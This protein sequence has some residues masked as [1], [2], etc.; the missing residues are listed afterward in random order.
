MTRRRRVAVDLLFVTG[1]R[2]G[3]ETYAREL[4]PRLAALLEGV[5]LVAVT[6]APGADLVRGWFPGLVVQLDLNTGRRAAWAAAE[7]LAAG[8][9]AARA[10][11]DLLWCP[12]NY[13]PAGGSVPR[14]VT[15]HD[16]IPFEHV[17]PGLGRAGQRVTTGLLR[18]AAR[19]ATRLLAVSE[20][21]ADRSARVLGLPRDRFCVVP[22]GAS[23]LPIP[24]APRVAL[25]ALGVPFDR[26]LV[27]STGNRMPHKNFPL[28][29]RALAAIP[30]GRRPRLV[31]PGGGADD[32]LPAMVGSL[33]L[34][35]DVLL[36]GWL[37]AE[38]LGAL[39]A[40]AA[41]Y[42]CPSLDEGFGLPVVDAMRAGCPVLAS[43]I[44]VLHEVGEDAVAYVDARDAGALAAA[45]E[46]LLGDPERRATLVRR[47]RT[48][49]RL[50]TWDRSAEL[51]AQVVERTLAEVGA[52]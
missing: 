28:L 51:T 21:G 23:D 30:A 2:G 27:L 45:V 24:A 48:R 3:T 18:R 31:L 35:N 34:G 6:G 40:V 19:G 47:G 49:A 46:S 16:V 37:T 14:L 7:V 43:D 20:D 25:A 32:P 33:G 4:L 29:L 11:A 1:R 12:A 13:G 39:H 52:A 22:N 42:V 41:L 36:P 10:R 26:P 17:P 9:A 8:R 44:P 50:F 38:Q 5:E 15:V